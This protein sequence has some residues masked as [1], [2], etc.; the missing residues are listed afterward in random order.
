MDRKEVL[1]RSVKDN[2]KESVTEIREILDIEEN[3]WEE[4]YIEQ[5]EKTYIELLKVKKELKIFD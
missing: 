3:T 4:K 5:L 2:I 1:I